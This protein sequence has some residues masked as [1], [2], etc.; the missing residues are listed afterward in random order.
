MFE[1]FRVVSEDRRT[2][3]G[4]DHDDALRSIHPKHVR[5]DPSSAAFL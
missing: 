3:G 2:R 5:P 1:G 4:H